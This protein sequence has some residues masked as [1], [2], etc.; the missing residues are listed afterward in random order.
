MLID[1]TEGYLDEVKALAER[2]GQTES[3][4][5]RLEYLGNYGSGRQTRCR[6]YEDFDHFY[7]IMEEKKEDEYYQS[8]RGLLFNGRPDARLK[9]WAWPIPVITLAW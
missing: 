5:E 7:F 2:T 4:Q 1:E 8:F 9:T 3:L 6:L